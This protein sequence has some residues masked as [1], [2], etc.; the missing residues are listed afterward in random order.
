MR[1]SRKHL[2][3]ALAVFG[4]VLVLSLSYGPR[5]LSGKTLFVKV[6]G[7]RNANGTIHVL[8]YDR[9]TA[10][11]NASQTGIVSY[12]T[13]G[14]EVGD[15]TFRFRHLLPGRY[16]VFVHHDENANNSFDSTA[17][18]FE[19]Y[20]YSQNVGQLTTPSFDAAAISMPTDPSPAPIAMVYPE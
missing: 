8:I 7:V 3:N 10:F 11:E 20:G 16:A 12:I 18:S 5:L 6:T 14:A 1:V 17:T 13:R 4:L 15:M 2:S 9:A 19:G